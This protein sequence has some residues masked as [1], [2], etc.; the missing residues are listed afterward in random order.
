MLVPADE[1][2]PIARAPIQSRRSFCDVSVAELAH[3]LRVGHVPVLP[4]LVCT[5]AGCE[6]TRPAGKEHCDLCRRGIAIKLGKI[7]AKKSR[8]KLQKDFREWCA[9]AVKTYKIKT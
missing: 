8:N 7:R 3:R 6:L 5:R 2:Q 4:R 9:T 1:N